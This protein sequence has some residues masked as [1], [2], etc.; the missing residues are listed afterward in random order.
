[1]KAMAKHT[2]ECR[3]KFVRKVKLTPTFYNFLFNFKT[4]RL[5]LEGMFGSGGP[6]F[7]KQ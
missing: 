5:K 2:P 7:I 3:E 1:M 4:C 6:F